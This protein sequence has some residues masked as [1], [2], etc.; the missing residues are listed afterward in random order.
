MASEPRNIVIIGGGIIGC[1]SAYFLTRHPAFNP[2]LHSIT[3]LE[4][5]SIAS[6]AS[7]KAGGLLALWAYPA[8]IV[9]LSYRLHAELAKEHDGAKRWGYR[10]VHCGSIDAKGKKPSDGENGGEAVEGGEEWKKLPKTNIKQGETI[11]AEIPAELDWFDRSSIRSY[12]EMG[13]PNTTAQVHPF[14]FTTSMAELAQAAGA[15]IV[16]G[17]VTEID[18]TGHGVKGVVYTDKETKE[19]KR[20]DATDVILAAGP[21]SRSIFP[22][23]PIDALRAHSVVIEAD[24]SPYAVFTEIELPKDFAVPGQGKKRRHGKSV[25]PEMYARPDGTVYACGEGDERIPLPTASDLVVCDESSC[26]DMHAYISSISPTL[27]AGKVLA[28]QACYLPLVSTGGGPIIGDTGIKG[29]ILASGHTCW[30]IQ[31]SCATGK[32]VSEFVFEGAAKSA[33][34]ES[35]DPRNV[36]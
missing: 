32:L 10:A 6:G 9:P 34:I 12:T 25:N 15:K 27:K 19:A 17:S 28:K 24:V 8:C 20:L 22:D 31:N 26:D 13:T 23:A 33:D 4:A 36:M 35:L 1:T 30:G 7:G 29:L 2:S 14:L 5:T 3:I 21:W 16:F 11:G 18:Y